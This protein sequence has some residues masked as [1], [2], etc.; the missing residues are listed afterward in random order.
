MD[1]VRRGTIRHGLVRHSL[2]RYGPPT[3]LRR[4]FPSQSSFN[5]S[6]NPL[7]PACRPSIGGLLNMRNRV[8]G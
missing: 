3:R 2:I 4:G 7:T 8:F 6:E 1:D 5:L